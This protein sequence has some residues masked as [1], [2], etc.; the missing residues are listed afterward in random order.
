MQALL[1]A[2]LTLS[3]LFFSLQRKTPESMIDPGA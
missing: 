2:K 1:T 3:I